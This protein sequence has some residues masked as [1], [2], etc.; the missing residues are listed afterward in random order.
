MAYTG[1]Y[2]AKDESY[3]KE[4][5]LNCI[6]KE[7]A[8]MNSKKLAE[9]IGLNS[10]DI[11]LLIQKL[12]DDGYPICATPEQGYWMARTSL[13][14][15]DTMSKLKSHIKN[16]IDTYNSLVESQNELKRKEGNNE[17]TELLV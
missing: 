10:R 9:Y 14:M 3:F 12:R 16:S 8:H 11:R 7:P 15:D 4:L 17:Y 1:T 5:I 13:D 6:P 2:K